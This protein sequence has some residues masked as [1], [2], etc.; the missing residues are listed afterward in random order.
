MS[1]SSTITR[2]QTLPTPILLSDSV[3]VNNER[4]VLQ[5]LHADIH[6]PCLWLLMRVIPPGGVSVVAEDTGGQAAMVGTNPHGSAQRLAFL[7]E[8]GKSLHAS[9]HESALPNAAA[10]P[11][12]TDHPAVEETLWS[13]K[14]I[15]LN[16]IGLMSCMSR[17]RAEETTHD[18]Q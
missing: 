10:M 4:A 1:E 13:S 7:H 6:D 8:R 15:D 3:P 12:N 14:L 11:H 18:W 17:P 9:S 16:H 2:L 5:S